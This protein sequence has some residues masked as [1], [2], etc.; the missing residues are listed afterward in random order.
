MRVEKINGIQYYIIFF[1]LRTPL[2]DFY[3]ERENDIITLGAY[4]DGNE[5]VGLL[6]AA[7]QK[8]LARILFV[9]ALPEYDEARGA[10]VTQLLNIV[11]GVCE[12]AEWRIIS[13]SENID[14]NY[15]WA[16]KLLFS[17][18]ETEHIFRHKST[19][20]QK[21]LDFVEK[22]KPIS[23]RF[24]KL[25][26]SVK[27]FAELSES[28]LLYIAN[29]PDNQFADFLQAKEFIYDENRK[30]CKDKSFACIKDGKVAAF[31]FVTELSRGKYIYDATCVAN[32]YKRSGIFI[33]VNNAV[34]ESVFNS[35]Y[36]FIT[37]AVYDDNKEMLPVFE[38]FMMPIIT[39]VRIQ[40]NFI[41]PVEMT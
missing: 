41:R 36:S 22:F 38:E 19:D 5:P 40:T 3:C 14:P 13:D 8:G 20:R 17:K 26:Y 28:E 21:G 2:S 31:A 11:K 29:D 27:S 37:F 10:M 24:F 23:E 16:E 1:K 15:K 35:D 4:N 33:L 9:N 30:L 7:T 6:V 39:S 12:L 18:Q 34:L 25:G 32:D